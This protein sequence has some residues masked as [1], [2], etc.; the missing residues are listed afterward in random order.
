MPPLLLLGR[1]AAVPAAAGVLPRA[2]YRI[3]LEVG[4]F[5]GSGTSAMILY[6]VVPTK[7]WSRPGSLIGSTLPAASA[8]LRLS[9]TCQVRPPSIERRKPMPGDRVSPSP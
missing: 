7:R 4:N 5:I 8:L 6:D 9:R 1:P 2:A 3:S